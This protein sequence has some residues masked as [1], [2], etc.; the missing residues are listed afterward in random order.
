MSKRNFENVKIC[1]Y[2]KCS[3]K[4]NK[5]Q[6]TQQIVYFWKADGS[7]IFCHMIISIVSMCVGIKCDLFDKLSS[8]TPPPS[9]QYLRL[10]CEFRLIYIWFVYSLGRPNI[11]IIWPWQ[12]LVWNLFSKHLKSDFLLL[13]LPINW[14]WIMFQW[15]EEGA[16]SYLHE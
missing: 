16:S 7:N 4:A 8:E 14:F 9:L 11:R 15:K 6:K 13:H 3:W 1:V 5:A 2:R 10:R 12:S